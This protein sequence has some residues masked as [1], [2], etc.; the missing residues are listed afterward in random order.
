[1]TIVVVIV[2]VVDGG[3]GGVENSNATNE[4]DD[5][6]M[7]FVL[8]KVKN[9]ES[10]MYFIFAPRTRSHTNTQAHTTETVEGECN[11]VYCCQTRFSDS[12]QHQPGNIMCIYKLDFLSRVLARA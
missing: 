4:D 3:G 1:M 10:A 5:C 9:S 2:I 8:P 12:Y 6:Q 11:E 7:A